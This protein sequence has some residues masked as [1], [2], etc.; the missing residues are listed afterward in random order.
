MTGSFQQEIVKIWLLMLLIMPSSLKKVFFNL[1]A[2]IY[3]L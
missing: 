3:S 1:T 2:T